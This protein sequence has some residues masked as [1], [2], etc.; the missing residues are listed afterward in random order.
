M[1]HERPV[2]DSSADRLL[3]CLAE[4]HLKVEGTEN[5]RKIRGFGAVLLIW[6]ER[7]LQSG[8]ELVS[9]KLL[10]QQAYPAS[11]LAHNDLGDSAQ[12]GMNA[13]HCGQL[14]VCGKAARTRST[15]PR[16]RPREAG[17]IP[18]LA[19]RGSN[20]SAAVQPFGQLTPREPHIDRFGY[21]RVHRPYPA[22]IVGRGFC[23]GYGRDLVMRGH[24]QRPPLQLSASQDE[25]PERQAYPEQAAGV[26]PPCP[27]PIAA[28]LARSAGP[29]SPARETSQRQPW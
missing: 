9:V 12:P 7:H 13:E 29:S 6:A 27:G 21:L 15:S 16:T 8:S 10:C 11:H 28:C 1:V 17:R 14:P 2:C 19:E 20:T 3:A 24:I 26:G 18:D 25:R 4:N 5:S 22:N 23:A